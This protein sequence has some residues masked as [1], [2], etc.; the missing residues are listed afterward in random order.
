VGSEID[1]EKVPGHLGLTYELCAGIVDKN[2]SW[3][4]I[5]QAEV[6]EECGYKVPLSSLE[7]VTILRSV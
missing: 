2:C 7:Q 6:F 5:A 1:S 4:E 3:D